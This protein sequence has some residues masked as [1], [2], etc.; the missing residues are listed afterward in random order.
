MSDSPPAAC[1]FHTHH[2]HHIHHTH[3]YTL[4][5]THTSTPRYIEHTDYEIIQS[6]NPDFNKAVVRVNVFQQ[7][8]RQTV[9]YI[10]PEDAAK[11]GQ[12]EL[13]VIDEAAAIPLPLVKALLGPYLVFMAST[14][15]GYEGTGRSLSLKLI[16]QLRKDSAA[17]GSQTRGKEETSVSGMG[18]RVLRELTLETPIRYA[19]GDAVET[20]LNQLLCLDSTVVSR[21]GSG[22]PHPGSCELY[23]VDRDTLFS[24]NP[25][26]EKF[27]QRVMS[28]YV[29]SH[30]KVGL[31]E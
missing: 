26:A 31:M 6:S 13:L 27:L 15:N 16:S 18:N 21:V 25:V 19:P 8:H 20:W 11:L 12:C 28:L 17:L 4:V 30:Y 29:A 23:T 24:Y 22:C 9:Q 14:V 5:D 3:A 10:A 7:D 1:T 2:T